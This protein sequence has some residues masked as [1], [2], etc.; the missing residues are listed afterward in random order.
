[1]FF[2]LILY[3][4]HETLGSGMPSQRLLVAVPERRK[5]IVGSG[6]GNQ[7]LIGQNSLVTTS[8][9]TPSNHRGGAG[10]IISPCVQRAEEGRKYLMNIISDH[11]SEE[12]DVCFPRKWESWH[13]CH[14]IYLL[15]DQRLPLTFYPFPMQ[16][17]PRSF[18]SSMK[19]GLVVQSH[20][21]LRLEETLFPS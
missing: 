10:S 13:S 3:I 21:M 18:T 2:L 17:Q 4:H 5:S 16:N 11:H 14:N 9:M 8:S 7:M 1:M 12:M 15:Y 6:V 20:S 19:P